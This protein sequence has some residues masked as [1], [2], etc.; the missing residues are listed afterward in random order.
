VQRP[1]IIEAYLYSVI[2]SLTIFPDLQVVCSSNTVNHFD[3]HYVWGDHH[4][5]NHQGD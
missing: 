4:Q 2:H 5:T 1:H 3:V